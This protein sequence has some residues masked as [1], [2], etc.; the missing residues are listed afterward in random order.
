MLLIS[1]RC[2]LPP[3]VWLRGGMP[4]A[5]DGSERQMR[6]LARDIQRC[7]ELEAVLD[8]K[9]SDCRTVVSYQGLRRRGRWYVPEP[10]A[11]HIGS[12]PI[13]FVSSNPGAGP[14]IERFDALRHMSRQDSDE[15][16]F[17]A[18]DGAFDD[19]RFPGIAHAIYNR[20][21]SGNPPSRPVPFW[22][23]C[24][25]IAR[26]LLGREPVPGAD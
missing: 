8:G 2:A 26:E 13:L 18:A 14:K 19:P 3:V 17:A 6:A 21:R 9:A 11:G 1:T 16:L 24:A 25:S 22:R 23:W 10:W 4:M 12:A 5:E 7:E 15:D 20:D